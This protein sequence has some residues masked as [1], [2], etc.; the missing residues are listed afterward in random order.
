MPQCD[1]GLLNFHL[2][3]LSVKDR[4]D[5]LAQSRKWACP[6]SRSPEN[7]MKHAEHAHHG[8]TVQI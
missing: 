3:G 2:I 4:P 6:G 1:I 8:G 7:E 5:Q